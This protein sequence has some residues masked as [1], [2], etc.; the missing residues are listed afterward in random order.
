MDKDRREFLRIQV[1]AD[2]E[3]RDEQ[4]KRLGRVEEAGGGGMRIRLEA[5]RKPL[6]AG[7][8]LRITV[9]EPGTNNV[10]HTASVLVRYCEGA[11]L[12]L[13]FVVEGAASA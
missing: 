1:P 8:R 7:S 10:I 12:G 9:V 5:D 2:A 3:A 11:T 4:G 13:E 6:A